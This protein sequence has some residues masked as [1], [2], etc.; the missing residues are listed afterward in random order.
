[1]PIV[2]TFFKLHQFFSLIPFLPF[3]CESCTCSAAGD[4]ESSSIL[5]GSSCLPPFLLLPSFPFV[6]ASFRLLLLFFLCFFLLSSSCIF[7][8][9]SLFCSFI[10]S[11]KYHKYSNFDA[12]F[13]RLIFRYYNPFKEVRIQFSR[14]TNKVFDGTLEPQT[15]NSNPPEIFINNYWNVFF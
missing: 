15:L 12:L 6:L 13:L 9:S 11:W 1:M 4:N 7:L 2:I 10:S 8:T 3:V 14:F 5:L